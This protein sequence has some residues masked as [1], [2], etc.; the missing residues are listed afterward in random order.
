MIHNN[1]TDPVLHLKEI[2]LQIWFLRDEIES[3][4][5]NSLNTDPEEV[6]KT[7][8]QLRNE[9]ITKGNE[10]EGEGEQDT[11]SEDEDDPS[12]TENGRSEGGQSRCL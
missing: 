11:A 5:S 9:Y 3:V 12:D 8:A 2:H 10:A 1:S 4:V 7:I 6:K